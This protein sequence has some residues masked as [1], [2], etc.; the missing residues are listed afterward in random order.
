MTRVY[1]ECRNLAKG[2]W[3]IL[4]INYSK[5][6]KIREI[7]N[8]YNPEDYF[9]APPDE[10]YDLVD[11]I[12]AEIE[13]AEVES[14]K[15]IIFDTWGYLIDVVDSKEEFIHKLE[16]IAIKISDCLIQKV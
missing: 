6:C 7:I 12:V 1:K 5:L 2:R 13:S 9:C 16:N 11:K 8:N 3:L 4:D 14:V 15:K 10:Y